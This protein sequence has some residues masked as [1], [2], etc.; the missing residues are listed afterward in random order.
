MM[1]KSPGGMQV[2]NKCQK[3][4]EIICNFNICVRKMSRN[5][6]VF[7]K[8][9]YF[10]FITAIKINVTTL[11]YMCNKKSLKGIFPENF[12]IKKSF[13]KATIIKS[14]WLLIGKNQ[15]N[16]MLESKA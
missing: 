16:T 3:L 13:R 14:V 6:V 11:F 7:V 1:N 4:C 8:S 10:Q 15:H 2:L 12:D 9:F 5:F